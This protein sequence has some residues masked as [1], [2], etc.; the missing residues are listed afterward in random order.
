MRAVKVGVGG[1]VSAL[2]KTSVFCGERVS[3]PRH[4]ALYRGIFRAVEDVCHLFACGN[5]EK[6]FR[7]NSKHLAYGAQRRNIGLIDAVFPLTNRVVGYAYAL[8]QL[9]LCKSEVLS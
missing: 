5:T 9:S 2:D 1:G 6:V 7:G 3:A 8:A 4:F